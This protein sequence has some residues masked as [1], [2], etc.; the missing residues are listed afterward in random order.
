MLVFEPTPIEWGIAH[1]L[2]EEW[3]KASPWIDA[4]VAVA[5][6]LAFHRVHGVVEHRV[7]QIFFGRW[8]ANEDALRRFVGSAPHFEDTR[9]LARAFADEASRFGGEARV[10]L[11]RR[12][13]G[14]LSRVAGNWD[15][16]PRQFREDD[17][18]FALMRAERRPLDL[19]ETR[20]D[21]P[22]VLALPMLDHGM[23]AGLVLLDL[24]GNGALYRP[25]EIALLG[26]AAHA[27]G[28]A[29]AA[30][31]ASLIDT[32]NRLLKAQLARLSGIVGD[33]LERAGA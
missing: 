32:E 13:D 1:L 17:P 30:L 33:R 6:Y 19:G 16:T 25:D 9:A 7:E 8:Q 18:A 15:A 11:Y 12:S 20:S 26:W 31:H 22:G 24:K 4:G 14:V 3:V 29:M 27:V 21:L 5:V 23:L 28:L 2:P 10:A